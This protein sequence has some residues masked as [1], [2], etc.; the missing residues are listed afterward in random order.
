[1]PEIDASWYVRPAGVRDHTSAGGV[2]VRV[3]AGRVLVALARDEEAPTH[4][5]PKGT[6]EAGESIEAAARREIE[7]E[8]GFTRLVKLADL[9]ACERCT[10]GKD[11]WLTAHYF[12]YRTDEISPQ[13]T[14]PA[15]PLPADW[16]PLESLP[17]M[18]W[19]EQRALIEEN[20]GRIRAL[21]LES[22]RC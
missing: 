9:G 20:R 2:V 11:V 18:F 13:P 22:V 19:P 3:E 16:F 4:V 14:D 12:L 10:L 17:P 8:A 15:H 1:M 5:L 7:E 21:A 6:L